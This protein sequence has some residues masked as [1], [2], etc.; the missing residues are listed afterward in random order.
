MHTTYVRSFSIRKHS[1]LPREK[2]PCVTYRTIDGVLISVASVLGANQIFLKPP[3][4]SLC[5][6]CTRILRAMD[7]V[8]NTHVRLVVWRTHKR[9]S[10]NL[11]DVHDIG[12]G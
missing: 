6:A 3:S 5:I 10:H 4:L 8:A 2:G 12:G 9:I 11:G 1:L 7:L